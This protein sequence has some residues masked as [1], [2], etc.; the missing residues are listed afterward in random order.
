MSDELSV[1]AVIHNLFSARAETQLVALADLR[2]RLDALLDVA[3]E[4]LVRRAVSDGATWKEIGRA[5]GVTS[6]TAH[7]RYAHLLRGKRKVPRPRR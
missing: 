6:S 7:R 5:I 2:G 4:A 1:E 3:Q